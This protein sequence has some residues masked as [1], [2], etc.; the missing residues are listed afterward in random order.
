MRCAAWRPRWKCGTAGRL[1]YFVFGA[2]APADG[3]DA[4]ANREAAAP[5]YTTPCRG[6]C[7]HCARRRVSEANRAAGPALRPEIVPG[8]LRR[9]KAPGG[10]NPAPT[11]KILCFGPTGWRW[12]L[13]RFVGE[14]HGPPVD[15]R[16][17]AR[18]RGRGMP[19]PY[20]PSEHDPRNRT[21]ATHPGVRRAGCPHPAAPR[22]RAR[23]PGR[24]KS[25]P[26]E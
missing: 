6:R 17:T 19:L 1:W 10:I 12:H 2:R 20:K 14:G 25:R 15:V 23:F 11:N 3:G 8:A 13:C 18:P 22:G 5:H 16:G 24:D 7:L 4:A 9:R 21:T 26:Y